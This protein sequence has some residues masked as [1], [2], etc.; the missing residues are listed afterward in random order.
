MIIRGLNSKA[1]LSSKKTSLN[2]QDVYHIFKQ[3]KEVF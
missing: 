2:K 1:N 3:A